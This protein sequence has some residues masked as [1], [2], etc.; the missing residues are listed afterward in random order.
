[1]NQSLSLLEFFRAGKIDV[2][3]EVEDNY[4]TGICVLYAERTAGEQ[5]YMIREKSIVILDGR[6]LGKCVQEAKDAAC[7]SACRRFL[8]MSVDSADGSTRSM[9]MR[10]VEQAHTVPSSAEKPKQQ[11][12][13]TSKSL[14]CP[15][16]PIPREQEQVESYFPEKGDENSDWSSAA[17]QVE[18]FGLKPASSLSVQ[19]SNQSDTCDK[20][21]D[22]KAF[23]AACAMPI[24]ILGKLHEC[25]GWTAGKIL[26]ER[27]EV[28]V[29][30]A[31]RYNGPKI[32]EREALKSLYSEAIRRVNQAA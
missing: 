28:I 24:T 18:F 6:N 31:N 23:Q 8:D 25:N 7:Q 27:P 20:D 32:E 17:E 5:E 22:E 10:L 12:D 13:V 3:F 21:E 26:R 15:E 1:M 2:D 29:E 4:V 30:F 16:T 14:D 19:N 9:E 11:K